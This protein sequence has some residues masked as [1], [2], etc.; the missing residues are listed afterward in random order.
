MMDVERIRRINQR[1]QLDAA[2]SQPGT[3]APPDLI[4]ENC[5]GDGECLTEVCNCVDCELLSD[6]P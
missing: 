2:L 4:C 6:I 5:G 1:R 3:M